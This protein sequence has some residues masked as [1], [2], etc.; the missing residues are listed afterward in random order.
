MIVL[1]QRAFVSLSL[2]TERLAAIAFVTL[3]AVLGS[4]H[5]FELMAHPGMPIH[6]LGTVLNYAAGAL[7]VL[8]LVQTRADARR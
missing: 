8:A 6:L 1:A 3:N 2:E 7:G 4:N 5:L